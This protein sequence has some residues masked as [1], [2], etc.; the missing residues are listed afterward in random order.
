MAEGFL[1]LQEPKGLTLDSNLFYIC[2][3]LNDQMQVSNDDGSHRYKW[4]KRG[5]RGGEFKGPFSI[6]LDQDVLYVGDWMSVSL[7]TR[8][9]AFLQ[10]LGGE[11]IGEKEGEFRF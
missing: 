3:F 8:E 2:D 10:R 9:G 7:F 6:L 4:G 11:T 1:G 5:S